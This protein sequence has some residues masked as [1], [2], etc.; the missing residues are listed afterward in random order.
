VVGQGWYAKCAMETKEWDRLVVLPSTDI[1]AANKDRKSYDK[2]KGIFDAAVA[3]GGRT[4]SGW[5]EDSVYSKFSRVR[6]EIFS[7][8]EKKYGDWPTLHYKINKA[9]LKMIISILARVYFGEAGGPARW[10]RV[11]GYELTYGIQET[12]ATPETLNLSR[13]GSCGVGKG[14]IE[15]NLTRTWLKEQE[16]KTVN[17]VSV[18]K[19]HCS[20]PVDC[21]A[22]IV[23]HEF[24]HFLDVVF[25]YA[26]VY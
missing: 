16:P 8:L 10:A 6:S 13:G 26:Q 19:Q 1:P 9:G 3:R 4:T 2:A 7:R 14:H 22:Y 18:G 20:H 24:T 15:I 23:A 17:S 25:N 21:M 12:S 5:N 11:T